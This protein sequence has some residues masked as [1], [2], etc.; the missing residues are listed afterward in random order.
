DLSVLREDAGMADD[1]VIQVVSARYIWA[2]G[3]TGDLETTLRGGYLDIVPFV[4]YAHVDN[5]NAIAGNDTAY[6]TTSLTVD[7]GPWAIGLTRTD[8][9]RPG[10]AGAG[11][12]DYL[13]ELSCTYNIT[14]MLNIGVSV[15]TQSVSGQKS[16]LVGL[17]LSYSGAR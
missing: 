12:H 7:R 9:R 15:G 5:E 6:L 3:S 1:E 14:G 2:P 16:N 17:A 4:E 11:R 8:K 10:A 13:N